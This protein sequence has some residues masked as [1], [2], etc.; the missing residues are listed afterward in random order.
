MTARRPSP[1]QAARRDGHN[2]PER[3]TDKHFDRVGQTSQDEENR[4]SPRVDL[5]SAGFLKAPVRSALLATDGNAEL[6][7]YSVT[8]RVHGDGFVVR[9]L[10]GDVGVLLTTDSMDIAAFSDGAT[11]IEQRLR[12]R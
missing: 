6:E 12:E 4:K 1:S 5:E 2:S 8:I 11:A 10:V 3:V 7:P 9:T